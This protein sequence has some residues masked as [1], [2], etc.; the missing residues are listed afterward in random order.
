MSLEFHNRSKCR[1]FESTNKTYVFVFG[2]ARCRQKNR[3]RIV[4]NSIE[5]SFCIPNLAS[6]YHVSLENKDLKRKTD[7]L[8]EGS[9]QVQNLARKLYPTLVH[10]QIAVVV[11]GV[12]H[13]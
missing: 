2:H 5:K 11:N 7:P 10:Q 9:D 1:G 12:K 3:L 8:E 13:N 6:I 4:D